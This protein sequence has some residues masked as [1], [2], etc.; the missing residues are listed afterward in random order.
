VRHTW[1]NLYQNFFGNQF[2]YY[3]DDTTVERN[4]FFE[5]ISRRRYNYSPSRDE[6][7]VRLVFPAQVLEKHPDY[8]T[9]VRGGRSLWCHNLAYEGT[10]PRGYRQFSFNLTGGKKRFLVDESDALCIPSRCSVIPSPFRIGWAIFRPFGAV[11]GYENAL[12]M[13]HSSY[14][15][16]VSYE[17]FCE[18]THDADPFQP[19]ALVRPR[20]A[21]FYPRAKKDDKLLDLVAEYRTSS[22]DAA[23]YAFGLRE[24]IEGDRRR[25]PPGLDDFIKW[26]EA[27][28][29]AL[30]PYGLVL[31]PSSR[32]NG[33]FARSF[34][35][36]SFG[37]DIY[38]EVHPFE[39]EIVKNEI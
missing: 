28:P 10:S 26:S 32:T 7:R 33:E 34:Y 24:Y 21:Y 20:M 22:R 18:I 2:R 38:E 25:P 15:E 9:L 5:A 4:P 16:R 8:T 36:I 13:M 17:E 30:H 39:L 12:R 23:G 11:F 29:L 31:A 19:G 27:N 35:R 37:G 3:S 6:D 14:G 1:L